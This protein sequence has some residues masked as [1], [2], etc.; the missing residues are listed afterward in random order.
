VQAPSVIIA[1]PVGPYYGEDF[2]GLRLE[3]QGGAAA[4]E[5]F[6]TEFRERSEAFP[7]DSSEVF[8]ARA[9]H[10]CQD[11]MVD[12]GTGNGS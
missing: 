10:I 7:E 1:V 11:F 9:F 3:G 2:A 5:L 8:A 4:V 12:S 6:P